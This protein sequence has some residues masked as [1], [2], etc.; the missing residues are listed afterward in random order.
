MAL[1][2]LIAVDEDPDVLEEVETQL[3]RRYGRPRN[4]P[5]GL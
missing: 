1:P 5:R 3:V 2:I 4:V